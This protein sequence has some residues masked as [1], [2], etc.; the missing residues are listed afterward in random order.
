M[1]FIHHGQLIRLLSSKK[2]DSFVHHGQIFLG[3][4]QSNLQFR[5]REEDNG[6]SKL[7]TITSLRLKP[8]YRLGL[9]RVSQWTRTKSD[10]RSIKQGPR[11]EAYPSFDERKRWLRPVRSFQIKIKSWELTLRP[12]RSL[13]SQLLNSSCFYSSLI[14]HNAGISCLT[15]RKVKQGPVLV[16]F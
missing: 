15:M 5:P 13:L 7:L 14:Y 6:S 4:L 10:T 11:S 3:M 2:L 1:K 12:K 8:E 16:K 9:R